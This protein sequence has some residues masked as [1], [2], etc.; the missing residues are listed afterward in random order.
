MTRED[1]SLAVVSKQPERED[2]KKVETGRIIS[3]DHL[4]EIL[5]RV[6]HMIE[7]E[8]TKLG[9]VESNSVRGLLSRLEPDQG[10][11]LSEIRDVVEEQGF[12]GMYVD[13]VM[14]LF[15][16][17]AEQQL[18]DL[19]RHGSI[20]SLEGLRSIYESF[21]VR[22]LTKYMSSDEEITC[23][24]RYGYYNKE[25]RKLTGKGSNAKF[26]SRELSISKK[27]TV[28][29]NRGLIF[30]KKVREYVRSDKF[31]ELDFISDSHAD[32]PKGK[33]GLM[34]TLKDK[35]FL[36]FCGNVLQDLYE[37]FSGIIELYDVR[38]E[39]VIG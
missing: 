19:K 29:K 9:L 11:A 23:S 17:T 26:R 20:P 12:P 38:H 5:G 21:L 3:S 22:E 4:D 14:E 16:P 32:V 35:D 27:E 6:S 28:E 13:Q 1:A 34:I 39:Y 30:K 8:R 2:K 33:Y 25:S 18:A 7:T 31:V 15:Y 37:E 10:I 24:E 36:R